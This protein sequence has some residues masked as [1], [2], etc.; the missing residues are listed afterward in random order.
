MFSEIK[1]K[2]TFRQLQLSMN[3]INDYIITDYYAVDVGLNSARDT[4]LFF[5][6]RVECRKPLVAY[7]PLSIIVSK[8]F[9]VKIVN[10]MFY[11]RFNWKYI[12][13]D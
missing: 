2:K 8:T 6:C 10:I 11:F 7:I 4:K 5:H 9:L 3:L 13:M 1:I 12:P